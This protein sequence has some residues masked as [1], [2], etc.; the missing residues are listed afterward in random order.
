MRFS[1]FATFTLGFFVAVSP[2]QETKKD[3]LKN[4][5]NVDI[6]FMNGST[7]RMR[8]QSE[9]VEIETIY[10]KLTIPAKDIRSI[11]FGSHLPDGYA[12]KIDAAV[13]HLGHADFREREKASAALLELGPYS[14]AA[15]I[16]ASRMKETETSTRGKIIVQKLQAKHP[17]VDLKIAAHD[18]IITPTLTLTGRILASSIKA[19]ADYFGVVELSLADMRTLR[20]QGPAGS[21]VSLAIDAG[22]YALQ[23]QW[24]ATG[25]QADGRSNLVITAKGQVDLLPE[26]GGQMVVGPNGG[27]MLGGGGG[28]GGG[29]FGPKGVKV[30]DRG[31]L[32]RG[33]I[34]ENGNVF[35]IGERF[36]GV[37]TDTGTLYLTITPSTYSPQSSGSYEVRV[38]T[39]GD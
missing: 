34:G 35:T 14:Y 29:G 4:E 11:E 33:K 21:D 13:K 3:P 6:H 20:A 23:G 16:D 31:G 12:E 10:G 2:A 30:V 9:R 26:Q 19:K 1:L 7:V 5:I 32:L 37:H 38:S 27:R 15:A 36:E 8:I 18:K 22:K 28:P 39:K 25:F 17:K 24:L